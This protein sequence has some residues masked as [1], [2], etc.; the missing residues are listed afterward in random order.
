LKNQ[1]ETPESEQFGTGMFSGFG[2]FQ[3]SALYTG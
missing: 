1:D 2:L 3:Q